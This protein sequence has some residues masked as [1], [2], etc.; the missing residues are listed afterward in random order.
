LMDGRLLH[1]FVIIFVDCFWWFLLL[2]DII[3]V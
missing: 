3:V 2:L 1:G